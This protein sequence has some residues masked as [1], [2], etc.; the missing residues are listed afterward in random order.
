ME[1]QKGAVRREIEYAMNQ[2]LDCWSKLRV[3][4]R[5][6]LEQAASQGGVAWA[7]TKALKR[8][9]WRGLVSVRKRRNRDAETQFSLTPTGWHI[10]ATRG[11]GQLCLA[12]GGSGTW[13][14]FD[15]DTD[16]IFNRQCPHCGGAGVS[17]EPPELTFEQRA[18]LEYQMY[19]DWS[20]ERR[21]L[22]EYSHQL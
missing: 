6:I 22:D 18:K 15:W 20:N 11:G 9:I 17:D 1:K 3:S 8:L 14:F 19:L 13:S 5:A 16:E 12:C 2:R 4:E 21:A 7:P 10:L